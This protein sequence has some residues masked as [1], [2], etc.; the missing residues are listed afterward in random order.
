MSMC[1]QKHTGTCTLKNCI[2]QVQLRTQKLKQQIFTALVQTDYLYI[3]MPHKIPITYY[4]KNPRICICT[5]KTHTNHLHPRISMMSNSKHVHVLLNLI[6]ITYHYSL[7][8][9]KLNH[10]ILTNSTTEQQC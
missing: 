2:Y 6:H 7:T 8:T 3:Y 9:Q 5:S 4:S 10:H 1:V